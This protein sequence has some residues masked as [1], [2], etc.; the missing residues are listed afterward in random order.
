[1]YTE[2]M[3]FYVYLHKRATDGKVFYVGKGTRY[4]ATA[5]HGR[6]EFWKNIVAKHGLV[7][8]YAQRGMQEW[9][10]FELEQELIS[11]YGRENL[12][13]LTDGGEGASGCVASDG[14]KLKLA[15]MRWT[16]EWRKNLSE[17]AKARFS[18]QEYRK[19]HSDRQKIRMKQPDVREKL[20][21]AAS[22]Q[23]SSEE[24]RRAASE[25]SI[26]Q[27]S[28]P[29]AREIARQRALERFNTP[30]KRAKHAQAKAVLCVETG[31]TFGA[32][33]LAS[34]WLVATI[35]H[36]DNSQISKVCR[37]KL[38]SAYGYTWRYV[39]QPMEVLA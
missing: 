20:R 15:A 31:V 6:S 23:F 35:G 36:G 32:C 11:M 26:R 30:E 39:T 9:W 7:V 21:A 29:A 10:A 24:A 16:P 27:F 34:E 13:N 5:K 28:N 17:K 25:I 38:K 3:D 19:R 14:T 22:A 4:R 12:C 18:D 37:G 8:E 33:T 2:Y 1:M